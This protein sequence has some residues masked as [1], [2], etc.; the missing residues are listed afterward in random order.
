MGINTKTISDALITC[1]MLF[2]V[3]INKA[4]RQHNINLPKREVEV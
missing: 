2:F 4:E 3:C 1:A